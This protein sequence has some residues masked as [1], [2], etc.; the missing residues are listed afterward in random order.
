MRS[1]IGLAASICTL[2]SCGAQNAQPTKDRPRPEPI[3]AVV[4]PSDFALIGCRGAE[5]DD[6]CVVVA[7]G[8]KRVLIGTPIGAI[9]RFSEDELINFDAVL[10]FSLREDDISGLSLYRNKSWRGGRLEPATVYGPRGID[11]VVSGI[12]LTYEASDA[13]TYLEAPP[14]GGFNAALL[15]ADEYDGSRAVAFDT[16]DLTIIAQPSRSSDLMYRISYNGQL[17]LL[18]RCRDKTQIQSAARTV[19]AC[20]ARWDENPLFLSN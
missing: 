19:S 13:Q 4:N 11:K 18:R 3:E 17:V 7:A 12:N 2:I 15:L 10:V 8:G 6:S 20:P 1:A 9:E 5:P 16:G 14:P